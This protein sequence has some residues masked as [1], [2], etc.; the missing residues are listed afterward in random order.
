[1]T[2]SIAQRIIAR[3][4]LPLGKEITQIEQH[5]E[6]TMVSS[7]N[8]QWR[9]ET[10]NNWYHS[11][12]SK[13]YN[14]YNISQVILVDSQVRP[15]GVALLPDSSLYYLNND[16]EFRAFFKQV[17]KFIEPIELATLLTRY[18][19]KEACVKKHQN[20]I[21]SKKDLFDHLKEEQI[22]AIPEFTQ[23]QVSKSAY[24]TLT[25]DFCSFFINRK[26]PDNIFRIGINRWRLEGDSQGNLKWSVRTVANE[27]D[28]LFYS[29]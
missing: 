6:A 25:L 2:R 16:S 20:L 10:W 8:Q 1:M 24:D 13:G 29:R 5:G 26:P 12:K 27:L 14:L 7:N 22:S 9:V 11:T 23:F 17:F 15:H 28:S 18:Q 3:Y 21:L 4:F 19:G